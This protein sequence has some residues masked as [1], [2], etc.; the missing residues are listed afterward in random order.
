MKHGL[1]M[2]GKYE[3]ELIRKNGR[4]IMIETSNGVTNEG[5][6]TIL[7][8]MFHNTAQT[9][10]WYVGLIDNVNFSAVDPSDTMGSHAGWQE[11]DN[12]SDANRVE[13]TE[14]A[15]S[16]GSIT[17]SVAISFNISADGS[18]KGLF[19]TSDN[20]KGG[21]VGILWATAVFPSAVQVIN[22]DVLKVTYTVTASA[23]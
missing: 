5:L 18:V 1:K 4:R 12:Y 16:N 9:P 10:T 19:L 15:S 2:K 14:D 23:S 21:S 20:T 7:D 6:N 11:L 22:G 3:L 17:N 13:W 8:N